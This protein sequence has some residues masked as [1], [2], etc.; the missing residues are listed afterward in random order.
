MAAAEK[1]SDERVSD[2]ALE[3]A[4]V[5]VLESSRWLASWLPA[6]QWTEDETG[7]CLQWRLFLL[8]DA[9]SAGLSTYMACLVYMLM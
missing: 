8:G 1:E 2:D 5:V 7:K 9:L 3:V 6:V 4:K